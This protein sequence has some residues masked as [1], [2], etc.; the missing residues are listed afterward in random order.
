M[1]TYF[2]NFYWPLI[3]GNSES[4]LFANHTPA[5]FHTQGAWALFMCAQSAALFSWKLDIENKISNFHPWPNP[6]GP[7]KTKAHL[8]YWCI[9]AS[10]FLGLDRGPKHT[11]FWKPFEELLGQPRKALS[12]ATGPLDLE[13][14]NEGRITHKNEAYTKEIDAFFDNLETDM[15]YHLNKYL[16]SLQQL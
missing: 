4:D 12:R 13:R 16:Q 6:A 14:D 2:K 15:E 11:T 5:A 7:I 1:E 10:S 8:A 9:R 3:K